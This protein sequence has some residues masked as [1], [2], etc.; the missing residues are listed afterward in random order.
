MK[1]TINN[2]EFEVEN[3]N[4]FWSNI[5]NWEKQSFNILER[6]LSKDKIFIDVGAWNGVLSIY[7][8]IFSKKVYSFE[9]DK[10]AY[11]NLTNNLLLNNINNV[12]CI[13]SGASNIEGENN[14]YI[15]NFGDSVSS[16]IDRNMKSYE[17]QEIVKIKTI[18]LSKFLLE[19]NIINIGLIKMD[20]EGGEIY[21]L[22]E[23]TEYINTYRP[24]MFI[25]FHPNW[26]PNKDL[27]IQKIS[28]LLDTNYNI[29][30]Q[31]FTLISKNKFIDHLYSSGHNFILINKDQ[32][33]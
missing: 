3:D 23:M 31:N 28:E 20:T 27:E 13:N 7:G 17:T 12:I 1:V 30:N 21:I 5:D 22:D 26:F 10:V 9:P 2:F 19:N 14:F 4:R 33:T 25:S 6:F 15:R 8:S 18:K 11:N 32:K 29:Y 24:T 16:L